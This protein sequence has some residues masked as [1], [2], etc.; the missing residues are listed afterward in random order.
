MTRVRREVGWVHVRGVWLETICDA[1][2]DQTSNKSP[3]KRTLPSF[4][5]V[6]LTWL[7]TEKPAGWGV[8][9]I[10][11][12][13]AKVTPGRESLNVQRFAEKIVRAKALRKRSSGHS[14][15]YEVRY[16]AGLFVPMVWRF[17]PL[18]ETK[19]L[20]LRKVK[21]REMNVPLEGKKTRLN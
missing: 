12:T 4:L 16:I 20:E 5:L 3:I 19:G 7:H 10:A 17:G 21:V 14:E 15:I 2:N 1:S 8:V 13:S 9:V 18:P 6:F 11:I